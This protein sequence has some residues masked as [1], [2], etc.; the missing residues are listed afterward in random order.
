MAI[1]N[2]I[3]QVWSARLQMAFDR[4][5]VF[6]TAFF[7]DFSGEVSSADRVHIP[8]MTKSVTVSD[9]TKYTDINAAEDPTDRSDTLLLDQ[10]KYFHIEIDDLDRVQSRPNWMD[11]FAR[12]AAVA[13]AN[14]R[15]DYLRGVIEATQQ[16]GNAIAVPGAAG[17]ARTDDAI[18]DGFIN[19][20]IALRRLNVPADRPLNAVC[21]PEVVMRLAKGVINNDALSQLASGAYQE[22][23]IAKLF[24]INFYTS[25]AIPANS[26][27]AYVGV[28]ECAAYAGQVSQVEAYRPEKRFGDALKG[29]YVYGAKPITA[30]ES[31]VLKV[32]GLLSSSGK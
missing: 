27:Y 26:S 6:N 29:L 19:A 4:T 11:E 21:A 3:G 23:V 22:G 18:R 20:A 1:T 5:N 24:G 12:K 10:K 13:I 30:G 17:T 14:T 8:E 31:K 15:D 32:T 9:Y 28:P 7:T 16:A 25:T 2:F